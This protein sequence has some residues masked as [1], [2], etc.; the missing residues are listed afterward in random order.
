M[1]VLIIAAGGFGTNILSDLMKTTLSSTTQVEGS[2][3]QCLLIDG[4]V[5][6]QRNSTGLGDTE[7]WLC[8]PPKGSEGK[9]HP[10]AGKFRGS[11]A[12]DYCKFLAGKMADLPFADLYLVVYSCMGGTGSVF[13]PEVVRNLLRQRK[14]VI[15]LMPYATG[16]SIDAT[17]SKNVFD[18][19]A[20]I[21][22]ETGAPAVVFPVCCDKLKPSEVNTTI[23]NVINSLIY[24][25]SDSLSGFDLS[26]LGAFLNY[27]THG[28]NATLTELMVNGNL[29]KIEEAK[30]K[31]L[32][33]ISL[34][35]TLD[36]ERPNLNELSDFIATDSNVPLYFFTRTD[37]IFSILDTFEL[38]IQK[39]DSL[40][41][42]HNAQGAYSDKPGKMVY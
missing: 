19:L 7:F 16:S 41:E 4:S 17:N 28:I 1:K 8:P 24:L 10:G 5:S 30:G 12:A 39:Y 42:A 31:I 13:G 6:N 38:I 37:R 15:S 23:T 14:N 33:S 18:G 11:R 27:T 29:E 34:L 35:K 21:A 22:A 36:D 25:T 40:K 20:S 32:T 26:D 3:V 2:D 9:V